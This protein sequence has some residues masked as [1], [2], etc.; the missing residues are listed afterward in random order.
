MREASQG[1]EPE[2]HEVIGAAPAEPHMERPAEASDR[3]AGSA[4]LVSRARATI[5]RGTA[6]AARAARR[7]TP[8]AAVRSVGSRLVDV[9]G[10]EYVDYALAFGPALLGHSPPRV[11]ARVR[12]QLNRGV[13]HG[14]LHEGEI[15]LAER[16]VRLVPGAE[17]VAFAN[18]GSDAVHAAIRIAR[19]ATGRHLVL[20]FEGHYHGWIDPVYVNV[21]GV[22]AQVGPGPLQVVHGIEGMRAPE[23]VVVCR[24]NDLASLERVL[25][26]HGPDIAL[27]L[28]E[29]VACNFGN[30]EPDAGYLAAVH[31]LCAVNGSLLA[32]DEVITGFRLGLGGAQEAHGVVPDLTIL[33]KALASGFP[34]SLVAGREDTMSPAHTG[35]VQH[36]GTYNGSPLSVAAANATLEELE[37][38]RGEIYPA[39]A[40]RAAALAD[41]ITDEAERLGAPLVVSRVASVLQLLWDPVTPVRTYADARSADPGPVAELA[42]ELLLEGVHVLERGLWFLSAAHDDAD[43]ERTLDATRTALARVAEAREIP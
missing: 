6:S 36:V 27:V 16:V 11:I 5:V 38:R 20:K 28:M 29:P 4:E 40:D 15:E 23:G 32:F 21:P 8:L 35:P 13:L 22:P 14:T 19:A 43:V 26:L 42:R 31:D 39:L 17:K 41:G 3:Y 18:A 37:E 25:E 9:D 2:A 1:I 30:Y 24:W 7:P 34:I 10:N 33:A 12:E